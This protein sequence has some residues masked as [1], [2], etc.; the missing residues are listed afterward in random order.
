MTII[1]L[2]YFLSICNYGKIRI[3]AEHL[4]V[5]EPTISVSI[6]RLEDEIGAPL[7]IR[8][9]K[10]LSLTDKG[11][12]LFARAT[13]VVE[14]FDKL[15]TDLQSPKKQLKTIRLGSPSTLNIHVCAPL[16]AEFT[17]LYPSVF[18][19]TPTMPPPVA[20][21]QVEDEQLELAV[22][23]RLAVTSHQLEFY[24]LVH[25]TLSGYVRPDHPLAGKDH[26]TP[27]MLKDE[28][29]ILLRESGMISHEIRD[30]FHSN[31]VHP[32]FFMHSNR[33]ILSM[34]ISMIKR[35]NALAFLLDNLYAWNKQVQPFPP[36]DVARFTLDPPM[37][38]DFGIVR[39]RGIKLSKDAQ[40]FLDFC[41][42]HEQP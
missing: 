32:N 2:K 27:L 11:K 24:P 17:E 19:E 4:H 5:S 26:V 23:D 18:F 41:V 21:Q 25:S 9:R 3:A 6:K 14:S 28:P 16:I 29:L 10:Q 31:G 1:Q 20:A 39:K 42:Q 13:E 34:T 35:Q 8:N 40:R 33:D 12:L 37:S 22:C 38:F 15:E 7:F 36:A 30:W